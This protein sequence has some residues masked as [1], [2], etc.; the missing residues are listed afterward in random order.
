MFADAAIFAVWRA[1]AMAVL[2]SVIAASC[3]H[4]KEA[5]LS[6][7]D[8][9]LEARVMRV[10]AEM[11][12]LVCQNE[13]IAASNAELAV[14]LR[15]Q[16][17]E[18]LRSGQSERQVY[19]YMTAR[20]GDFVLYRPPL[21]S[22]TAPLWFAPPILLVAGLVGLWWMLRRRNRLPAAQFEHDEYDDSPAEPPRH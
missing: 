17:R 19:D 9:A 12:C 20:Y 14:D 5:A 3:V 1:L 22:A 11:R 2:L 4:A 15:N 21:R 16:V 8:P 18:M 7:A 13:T 10:A 6:A